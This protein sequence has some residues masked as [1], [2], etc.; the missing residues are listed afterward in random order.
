M[1]AWDFASGVFNQSVSISAQD[2]VP[3]GIFFR[4]DGLKMYHIGDVNN[5]V[6]EYD[7]STSFDISTLSFNQSFGVGISDID[8]FFKSD[9]FR[10][11][12]LDSGFGVVEYNLSTAW[13]ISTAVIGNFKNL[14][15]DSS[16]QDIFFTED[17]LIMYMVGSGSST[18]GSS[19]R[20]Y[21]YNLSTAWD[22]TTSVFNQ[23]F[24]VVENFP[25]GIFFKTDGLRMFVTGAEDNSFGSDATIW[26]YPLTIPFDISSTT[27]PIQTDITA[28]EFTPRGSFFQSNGAKF[29]HVGLEN[30]SVYEYI[31]APLQ[32]VDKDFTV[33]ANLVINKEIEFTIDAK[34]PS[35]KT[36]TIDGLIPISLAIGTI[37]DA[38]LK[39]ENIKEFT[40][41]GIPK[42]LDLSKVF[43]IDALPFDTP[44]RLFSVN[45]L[46]KELDKTVD[47]IVDSNIIEAN[48]I[49]FSIG[50]KLKGQIDKDF[51]IEGRI[52]NSPTQSFI[53]DAI[54]S[55]T[56]EI[57]F[58]VDGT[59][60]VPVPQSILN[61]ESVIGNSSGLQS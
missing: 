29:Y 6:Y 40:I 57:Q 20:I 44:A 7:L 19:D 45:T 56:R 39:K 37:L 47:F 4:A 43:T 11:F 55:P 49:V 51:T 60:N 30:D 36:F 12:I 27:P 23:S 59:T 16:R 61:V 1:T 38:F 3:T 58:S 2:T 48:Q 35:K 8:V 17:G 46:L 54:I 31:L 18:E 10:M 28:I 15:E 14:P 24:H 22:V 9:G 26:E 21:R 5:R 41:D 52:V 50:A 25:T 13:D 33:D 34:I 42:G 53:M 32:T